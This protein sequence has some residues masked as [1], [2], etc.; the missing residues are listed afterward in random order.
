MHPPSLHCW[1][2][3]KIRTCIEKQQSVSFV[4]PPPFVSRGLD[5][6]SIIQKTVVTSIIA[7][8]ATTCAAHPVI[9]N[10]YREMINNSPAASCYR[11]RCSLM[12]LCTCG[13][14]CRMNGHAT[15]G[16]DRRR[17]YT[18]AGVPIGQAGL[19]AYDARFVGTTPFGH[20]YS[21]PI[22]RLIGSSYISLLFVSHKMP[23]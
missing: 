2:S 17:V 16:V 12:K 19:N 14:S 15:T 3:K 4:I 11:Q 22:I 21:Q 20:Q 6:C 13:V 8:I 1:V 10:F 5:Y 23:G 9:Y 18:E 7:G